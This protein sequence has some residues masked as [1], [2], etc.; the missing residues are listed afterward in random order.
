MYGYENA[1]MRYAYSLMIGNIA[2]EM[3]LVDYNKK[4]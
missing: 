4:I 1:G 3:V 2:R